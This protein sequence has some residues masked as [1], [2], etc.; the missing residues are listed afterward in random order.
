MK[1][2]RVQSEDTKP[3]SEESEPPSRIRRL[4]KVQLA[5]QS[6]NTRPFPRLFSFENPKKSNQIA[7]ATVRPFISF[8]IS[9]RSRSFSKRFYPHITSVE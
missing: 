3:L 5:K 1:N 7:P 8:K 6:K 9:A 4:A 2:S